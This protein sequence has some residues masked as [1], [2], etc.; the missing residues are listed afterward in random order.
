MIIAEYVTSR[1]YAVRYYIG[2]DLIVF[3]LVGWVVG[4]ICKIK[5]MLSCGKVQ[6][7]IQIVKS[8]PSCSYK[9]AALIYRDLNVVV[10]VVISL[11]IINP[12]FGNF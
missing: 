10:V 11:K 12:S 2:S 6:T 9:R 7:F 4:Y 1:D 5:V 8:S 3:S